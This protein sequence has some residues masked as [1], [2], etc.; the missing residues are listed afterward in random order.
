MKEKGDSGRRDG[1]VFFWTFLKVELIRFADQ[2]GMGCE[3]K[4]RVENKFQMFGLNNW[5]TKCHLVRWI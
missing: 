4:K 5:K 1:D 3:G 2:L